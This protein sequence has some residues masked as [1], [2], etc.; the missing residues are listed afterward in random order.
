MTSLLEPLVAAATTLTHR[1]DERFV[2]LGFRTTEYLA[3][4]SVRTRP[5]ASAAEVR[6]RLRMRDAAFSEVVERAVARGYLRARP[7][8]TDRRT[9]MLELTLPG[10]TATQ[11][12]RSIHG[13]VEAEVATGQ[14]LLALYTTLVQIDRSLQVIQPPERLG[15]GLPVT[16]I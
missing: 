12:A 15:D 14:D 9:R 3:L 6:R 8:T 13:Q 4:W 7:A 1:L 2:E 16:T 10:R 5:E 11:I